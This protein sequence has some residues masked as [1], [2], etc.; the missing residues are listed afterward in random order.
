[1]DKLYVEFEGLNSHLADAKRSLNTI[2]GAYGHLSFIGHVLLGF[3]Q[4]LEH[5]HSMAASLE[6]DYCRTEIT[7]VAPPEPGCGKLNFS[8]RRLSSGDKVEIEMTQ[9]SDGETTDIMIEGK[10]YH[11]A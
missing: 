7:Q 4:Q 5:I 10:W 3:M 9:G 11:R 6:A 1:M 2:A 8:T